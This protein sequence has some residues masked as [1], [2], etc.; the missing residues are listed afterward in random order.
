MRIEEYKEEYQIREFKVRSQNAQTVLSWKFKKASHF[1]IFMYDCRYEFNLEVAIKLLE[2][3]DIS[4]YKIVNSRSKDQIYDKGNGKFKLFCLREKEFLQG[5]KSFVIPSQE[6]KKGI[7]YE[8]CIYPCCYS[9]AMEELTVFSPKEKRENVQYIPV[10]IQPEIRYEKKLFTKQVTCI[11]VLPRLEDY[12]D[13]AIMYH[14][15]GVRTDFPLS[16]ECLG[17]ELFISVPNKD[18]LTVRIREEYKN[19]Y[20]KA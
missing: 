18:A 2:K 12:K 13:G 15:E 4:D 20:R 14:I 5:N 11:L 9:S 1:L 19:Y 10:V 7:P 3:E 16:A 17:K 6:L 8:I